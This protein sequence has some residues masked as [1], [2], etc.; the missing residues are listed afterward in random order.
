M[1]LS[2]AKHPSIQAAQ[3][4]HNSKQRYQS[5]HFGFTMLGVIF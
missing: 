5:I 4:Q 3:Q 2:E 1:L